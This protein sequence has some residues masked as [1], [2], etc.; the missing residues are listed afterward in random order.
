MTSA[1]IG[2]YIKNSNPQGRFYKTDLAQSSGRAK[3]HITHKAFIVSKLETIIDNESPNAIIMGYFEPGD[4][5]I[6]NQLTVMCVEKNI[7]MIIQQN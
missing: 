1:I 7:E 6:V 2:Q 3:Q 4:S 5:M